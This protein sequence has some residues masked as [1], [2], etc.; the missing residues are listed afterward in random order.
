MSKNTVN[1]H[2]PAPTGMIV[3][4][5]WDPDTLTPPA[6]VD[7]SYNGGKMDMSAAKKV[8]EKG[9]LVKEDEL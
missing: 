5:G 4:N 6:G 1:W 2:G 7:A 9:S 8:L 3:T